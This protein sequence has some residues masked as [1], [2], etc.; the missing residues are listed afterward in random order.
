[1][2]TWPQKP[3]Y[4]HSMLTLKQW[5]D[6]LIFSVNK[7]VFFSLIFRTKEKEWIVNFFF[8]IVPFVRSH[9]KFPSIISIRQYTYNNIS[10]HIQHFVGN[11]PRNEWIIKMGGSEYILYQLASQ[12]ANF[13]L[14]YIIVKQ[15]VI[16]L[17]KK[18]AS[19]KHST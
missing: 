4:L 3:T 5:H 8:A 14:L 17:Q 7:I 16:G 6:T 2:S 12:C 11:Q 9:I 19:T 15:N 10:I 1:M 13:T 18:A